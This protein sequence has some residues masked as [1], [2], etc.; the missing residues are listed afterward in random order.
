MSMLPQAPPIA[1][2]NV[3]RHYDGQQV[4]R[5][6]SLQVRPGQIHALLGRN[7]C[8]KTTALRILLGFLA[9]HAGRSTVLG[10][11]SRALGADERGRIGYVTEGHRLYVLMR[12]S[13]VIAFEAGTRPR[14]DRGF[15]ESALKRCA[16]A[17][18]ARVWNLSRGQRAQLALIVAVAS[19]PEVLV[20]DDPALGL[21]VVM[22][23]ELLDVL[24]DL[25][26]SRGVSV[27][28]SSHFLNDVER[29]A[30]RV[31]ILHD[32]QLIVD[33]TIDDLKARVRRRPWFPPAP[34]RA[35]PKVPGLLRAERRRGGY[36]LT[37]LDAGAETERALRD[38]GGRLG[39]ASVPTLEELFLDL[40]REGQPRIVPADGDKKEVAA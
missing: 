27:L 2:E 32:G 33:A 36:D 25:L 11:D 8:G 19:G 40:T 14:F 29:I 15:A 12:V 24:I 23:R 28:F 4:L 16:L 39:D 6:L 10:V 21:D 26:A 30:D 3:Y 22:R 35:P 1:F 13:E 5:G 20:C 38:E 18:A 17:P 31:S 9:P 7:G 37:L 34:D